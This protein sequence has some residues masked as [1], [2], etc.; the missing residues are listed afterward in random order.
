MWLLYN[1]TS[2]ANGIYFLG[3]FLYKKDA[4]SWLEKFDAVA[5]D[6]DSYNITKLNGANPLELTL[7][8]KKKR[9]QNGR[10]E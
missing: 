10:S 9:E 8:V 6:E 5:S 1:Q 7:E 3:T 2:Y 4:K